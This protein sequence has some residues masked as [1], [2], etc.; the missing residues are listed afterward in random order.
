MNQENEILGQDSVV[1]TMTHYGLDGPG[2][3]FRW[4]EIFHTH[5]DWTCSPPSLLYNGYPG[6]LPRR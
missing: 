4:R 5:P 2:I 3:K 6:L 1:N